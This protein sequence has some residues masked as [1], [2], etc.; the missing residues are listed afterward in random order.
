[1]V[2]MLV[3]LVWMPVHFLAIVSF[4]L[5]GY[6]QSSHAYFVK[7]TMLLLYRKLGP[8]S[9]TFF[10]IAV[11]AVIGAV[12]GYS[13]LYHQKKV[14]MLHSLPISTSIRFW[15]IYINGFLG[16]LLPYVVSVGLTLA[17][18]GYY[19]LVTG[20]LLKTILLFSLFHVL[21]YLAVYHTAIL[22]VVVTGNYLAGCLGIAALLGTEWAFRSL[23]YQYCSNF[24]KTFSYYARDD[25]MQPVLSVANIYLSGLRT[26]MKYT[27]QTT[28]EMVAVMKEPVLLMCI[29]S[30]V[31]LLLAFLGYYFRPAEA[32]MR[33]VA[34][35]GIAIV[36]RLTASVLGS[37]LAGWIM[38]DISGNNIWLSVTGLLLGGVLVHCIL[39]IIME[40]RLSA[41]FRKLW[42]LLLSSCIAAC[43]FTVFRFDLFGFDSKIPDE[44]DIA[45][46]A[47]S[48]APQEWDMAYYD[49]QGRYVN[50]MSYMKDHMVMTDTAAVCN[51]AA[52]DYF[53]QTGEKELHDEKGEYSIV[54][55]M[56]RM[57][58]GK[59]VFREYYIN[60]AAQADAVNR[61]FENEQ[62]IDAVFPVR[63]EAYL[64]QAERVEASF[65]CYLSDQQIAVEEIE[66][67]VA[68]LRKD[69]DTYSYT[70]LHDEEQCGV[71]YLNRSFKVGEGRTSLSTYSDMYAI[72]PSCKNTVGFLVSHGYYDPDA[73]ILP[74]ID[75]IEITYYPPDQYD[76][77][78]N[79]YTCMQQDEIS[80]IWENCMNTTYGNGWKGADLIYS[81]LYVTA[82]TKSGRIISL[83]FAREK[84]IPDFVKDAVGYE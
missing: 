15:T 13:Y 62:Y 8:S 26:E 38:S 84:G 28:G 47:L 36:A 24:F 45:S 54:S 40:F 12:Q 64:S 4:Q 50:G 17:I 83:S 56:Y 68:C 20:S 34:F 81:N 30:A 51:L 49:E 79:T 25:M 29:L 55:V 66:E 80:R 32:T 44:D 57:K 35:P 18:G 70:M 21:A 9:V 19:G 16:F 82:Y 22:A 43:V 10:L 3:L 31:T 73:D 72:Y 11:M 65:D 63:D 2:N 14:D 33:A 74:Q 46:Y 58:N 61:I 39:Q 78:G 69:L 23:I 76:A 77:T 41:A 59:R 52:A 67:L 48:F 75:K 37:L 7:D 60:L 6:E 1:M 27:L 71:L 5:R 53:H 42:L